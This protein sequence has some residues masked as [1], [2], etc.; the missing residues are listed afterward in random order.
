MN[1]RAMGI[2]RAVYRDLTGRGGIGLDQVDDEVKTEMLNT[3]YALVCKELHPGSDAPAE[4]PDI[5]E[6]MR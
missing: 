3:W 6:R 4:I 5:L 2:V 1:D